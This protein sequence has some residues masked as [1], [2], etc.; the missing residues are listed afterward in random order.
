MFIKP[1]EG[2]LCNVSESQA[3]K[4]RGA[5]AASGG[6]VSCAVPTLKIKSA[7]GSVGFRFHSVSFFL[8]GICD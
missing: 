6:F 8:G 1:L 7:Y 2:A 5:V 4:L 3:L